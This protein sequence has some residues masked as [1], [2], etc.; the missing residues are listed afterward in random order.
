MVYTSEFNFYKSENYNL[1]KISTMIQRSATTN[2]LGFGIGFWVFG[3]GIELSGSGV[4]NLGLVFFVFK[5]LKQIEKLNFERIIIC[6]K[7]AKKMKRT[8]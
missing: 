8:A 1:R 7:N 2:C 6:G 3:F 5:K 4:L